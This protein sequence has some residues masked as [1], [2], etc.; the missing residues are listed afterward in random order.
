MFFGRVAACAIFLMQVFHS[1][2]LIARL[3]IRRGER[4]RY[5]CQCNWDILASGNAA[6]SHIYDNVWGTVACP[7]F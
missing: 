4:I 1:S 5:V 3:L 6:D 2:Q 7:C